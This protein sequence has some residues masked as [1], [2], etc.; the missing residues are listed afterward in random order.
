MTTLAKPSDIK[1][2]DRIGFDPNGT[3][4]SAVIET[5]TGK[6]FP[7]HPQ[8]IARQVTFR[9]G[10]GYYTTGEHK[11]GHAIPAIYITT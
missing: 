6:D 8:D 2:G 10:H 9:V 3:D 5:D 7:F 4:A 11:D 1:A